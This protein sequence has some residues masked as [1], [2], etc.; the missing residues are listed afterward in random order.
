MNNQLSSLFEPMA[1]PPNG[2][3][4]VR[5]R[6]RRHAIVHQLRVTIASA[7]AVVMTVVGLLFASTSPNFSIAMQGNS[8]SVADSS[9]EAPANPAADAGVASSP[10]AKSND[11]LSARPSTTEHTVEDDRHDVLS[12]LGYYY[13]FLSLPLAMLAAIVALVTTK[14][15][16]TPQRRLPVA[17]RALLLIALIGPLV[18]QALRWIKLP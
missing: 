7:I 1:I 10:Q 17:S 3:E 11:A 13:L 8:A 14:R 12:R 5:R 18:A 6:A 4:D 15:A 9:A 16:S 2:L